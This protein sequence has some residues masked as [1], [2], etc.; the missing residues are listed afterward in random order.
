MNHFKVGFFIVA[1]DVVD[2][3]W[4]SGFKH[5]LNGL[6]MVFHIEPIAN[7]KTIAINRQGFSSEGIM[8]DQWDQLFRELEGSV[9]IG[10][11]RR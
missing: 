6:A 9:V 1:A 8:N 11:V 5:V 7:V 4:G 10:A 3:P 2:L